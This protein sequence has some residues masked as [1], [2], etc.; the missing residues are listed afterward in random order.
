MWVR[1]LGSAAGGG[2]PQWNCDCPNCRAVRAGSSLATPRTQSSLAISADYQHW[3][4]FNASPDIRTQI[5]A[6]PPLYPAQGIR[7]TP[8]QA[9][10]LSDAEI[11]HTLGLLVLRE[12]RSLRIYATEW[13]YHAL[14]AWNPLLRTLDTYCQVEWLP[15]KLLSPVALLLL[16]GTDSGLHCQPFTTLSGKTLTYATGAAPD[17]E[18]VVG[19]RITDIRTG[20]TLVYMP[21][22]QELN[23]T[24]LNFVQDCAC[25]LI[26]GTCWY[27]D[28]L[29]RLGIGQKTARAMGHLPISGTHGSLE[30]LSAL[31]IE[32]IVYI[33]INNTNPIL[34]E[35]SP[36]RKAVEEHGFVVAYDSMEM[37]I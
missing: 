28:E 11:D 16:D 37:E 4:L 21:A 34:L 10:V 13:V 29:A 33:H 12:N 30:Q 2:F 25:L 24:I 35:N 5:N 19:Y 27:D 9:I 7:H 8:I 32:R 22:V 15:M 1:V 31:S 18:S 6:S 3:F 14:T 36:Q 17:P 23:P 26:D 20:C